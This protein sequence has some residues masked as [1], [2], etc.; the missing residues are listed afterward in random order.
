MR[1]LQWFN[2]GLIILLNFGLRYIIIALVKL[3]GNKTRSEE[4]SSIMFWILIVQFLNMGPFLLLINSDLSEIGI[5]LIGKLITDGKHGDFTQKW[6]LD[7]GPI[8]V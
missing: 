4:T 3:R 7:I 5:P 8:I 2:N 1:N 6:Y